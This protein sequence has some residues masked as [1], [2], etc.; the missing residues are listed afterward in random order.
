MRDRGSPKSARAKLCGE[1]IPLRLRDDSIYSPARLCEKVVKVGGE[2][3]MYSSALTAI[4]LK[5][6]G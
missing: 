1:L 2:D 6:C 3:Q 5:S 4:L